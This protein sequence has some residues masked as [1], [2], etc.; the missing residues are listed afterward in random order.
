MAIE[1]KD[2][3]FKDQTAGDKLVV[4]DFWAV[5]CGPCKAMAPTIE[6]LHNEYLETVIVGKLDVDN[7]P[8]TAREYGIRNIPTTIFLKNGEIVERFVGNKPKSKF[9]EVIEKYI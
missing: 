1:F 8:N 5:W 4:I 3:T 7:N 2:D 6:A 9:V